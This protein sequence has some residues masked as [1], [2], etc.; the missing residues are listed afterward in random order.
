[1]M[2]NIE[3]NVRDESYFLHLLWA[4]LT[5]KKDSYELQL[6]PVTHI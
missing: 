1:M 3:N 4:K 5:K 2:W 6:I